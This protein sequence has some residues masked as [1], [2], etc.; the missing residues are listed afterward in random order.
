VNSKSSAKGIFARKGI[1]SRPPLALIYAMLAVPMLLLLVFNYIPAA[2]ALFHAFT[3]WDVGFES[4]FI[5]LANF[6]ELFTDGVFLKS[7]VNL[8]K[9]AVFGVTVQLTVPFIVAEMIYHLKSD[10]WSYW[11]RVMLVMPMIVP[12]VVIFM[13]WGYMYSDAGIVTE[14]LSTL[15]LY[16]YIYGWLSHP[17]TALW[18][19]A[20]VG[21][22]F[23]GGV[24]VLIYYAGLTNIPK[25][26]LEAAEVDGMGAIGRIIRI[27]IPLVLS[28]VKLLLILSVIGVV[29]GFELVYILTQDGGPGY[30]TMLPGLYM[31]LNGFNFNRMGYACAI[32]LV[33]MVFLL[34]FTLTLNRFMRTEAYDPGA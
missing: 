3:R 13:L 15:G 17:K 6:T 21:F 18:A 9:L 2:M 24:P 33:M 23:A 8:L 10:R 29:N 25:S 30:E 27:H 32:G 12:G 1:A 7:C 34:V 16:D 31:Y 22:P 11:C 5:G 4:T 26:I 28:Q 20:F 19:V 14:F